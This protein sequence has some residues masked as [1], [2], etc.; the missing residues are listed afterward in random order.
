MD[1][2]TGGGNRGSDGELARTG[3]DK[4]A[5]RDASDGM[6]GGRDTMQRAKRRTERAARRVQR[7]VRGS[8][9]GENVCDG[10]VERN[11]RGARG[12]TSEKRRET[13][14]RM[15]AVVRIGVEATVH[16]RARH[17]RH[18]A[19]HRRR[20]ASYT[21]NRPT[22]QRKKRRGVALSARARATERRQSG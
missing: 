22:M 11:K 16:A 12:D 19:T 1:K 3:G 5:D 14:K 4:G 2:D 18:H 17:E 6:A 9:Q 21:A 10:K 15:R 20:Q 8:M 7:D 13:S